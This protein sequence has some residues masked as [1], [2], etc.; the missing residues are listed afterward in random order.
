MARKATREFEDRTFV[1]SRVSLALQALK[2]SQD[3]FLKAYDEVQ[4]PRKQM[5]DKLAAMEE[6]LAELQSLLANQSRQHA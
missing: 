4:T 6:R 3:K 1:G 2:I 5:S